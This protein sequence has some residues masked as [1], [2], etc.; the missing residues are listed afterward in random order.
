M[1]LIVHLSR[2]A[3]LYG[4]TRT[5]RARGDSRHSSVSVKG[6]ASSTV[7]LGPVASPPHPALSVIPI[8]GLK[9]PRAAYAKVEAGPEQRRRDR[10]RLAGFG[11]GCSLRLPWRQRKR[12]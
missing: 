6:V 4:A 3:S 8:G 9:K 12:R 5:I 11:R 10:R 1:R 7:S 2:S